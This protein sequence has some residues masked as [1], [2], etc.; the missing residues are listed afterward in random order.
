VNDTIKN[1]VVTLAFLLVLVGLFLLNLISPPQAISFSERRKLQQFPAFSFA[2]L[3]NRK[4]FKEFERYSLDQFFGREQLRQLK[5]VTVF[6]LFRQKDNNGI[7]FLNGH[8][9]K[10]EYPLREQSV[11]KAAQKFNNIAQT[12]LQGMNV[13]YAIIPDK[14]Y[15]AA[16]P[17]GYPALDYRRLVELMQQNIEKMQYIDLFSC[18]SLSDYYRTDLHWRQECLQ[19]VVAQL[20]HSI[21]LPPTV[22]EVEY[23]TVV[24]Y[25]FYGAYFGQAALP[26]AP[27]ELI[28]LTN[29]A[30][31]DAVVYYYDNKE[32]G[33]VYA[34]EKFGQIDSY[35]LFL[36]GAV[37][38][39]TIENPQAHTDRELIIFRDSYGS[40]LAPLLLAGYRKITL[41]DLRYLAANK[42]GEFIEFKNQDVLFLYNTLILNHS[43]MLS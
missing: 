37:A 4:W 39:L 20:A 34:A 27:E 12:Y 26:L 28:Y 35:D 1:K 31:E 29:A 33:K 19:P 5:A 16:A 13:F 42:L 23:T 21:G 7:Y 6:H 10:M 3:V 40:S 41:V 32:Y 18:L 43:E 38:L 24:K 22:A 25:P 8:L 2:K 30:I 11:I 9:F 17:N 14:N 36:S 15:F